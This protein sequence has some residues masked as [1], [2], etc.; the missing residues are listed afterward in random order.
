MSLYLHEQTYCVTKH[1]KLYSHNLGVDAAVFL[2]SIETEFSCSHNQVAI[3]E[4]AAEDTHTRIDLNKQFLLGSCMITDGDVWSLRLKSLCVWLPLWR[5]PVRRLQ[6]QHEAAHS[7][8]A[9][10]NKL[11]D[12][13]Q[14]LNPLFIG[15][16]LDCS[17]AWT[18]MCK[19]TRHIRLNHKLGLQWRN[20]VPSPLIVAKNK[21]KQKKE[22]FVLARKLSA[23]RKLLIT[24]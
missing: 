6:D 19:Y 10:M 20:S 2:P 22:I 21:K 16:S 3:R 13:C 7:L 11:S 12:G 5:D 14:P 18:V 17:A 23:N 1:I 15:L 8:M 4:T 24:M 9:V